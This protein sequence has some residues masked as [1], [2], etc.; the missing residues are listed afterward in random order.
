M[1]FNQ[2][3]SGKIGRF[4]CK[5]LQEFTPEEKKYDL[6]WC[7][8]VLSHLTDDDLIQFL[9]RCKIGLKS[10]KS[11]IGIKENINAIGYCFDKND[12]SVTR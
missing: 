4:I 5:G 9:K 3:K 7:Q 11:I 1:F 8:W 2:K 6:I 10:N 12:S